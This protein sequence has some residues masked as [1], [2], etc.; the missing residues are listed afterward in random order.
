MISMTK[1]DSEFIIK[2]MNYW[3]VPLRLWHQWHLEMAWNGH[4]H[5]PDFHDFC[6]TIHAVGRLQPKVEPCWTETKT[7]VLGIFSSPQN[8]Q[9]SQPVLTIPNHPKPKFHPPSEVPA[10]AAIP[11]SAHGPHCSEMAGR[12]LARRRAPKA[13]MKALAAQ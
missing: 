5:R 13:S 12:S 1:Y 7:H 9:I 3:Q 10:R 11:T 8:L 4:I 6:G 2:F